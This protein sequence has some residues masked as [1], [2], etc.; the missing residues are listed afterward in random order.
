MPR[1]LPKFL[2]FFFRDSLRDICL[3]RLDS[4]LF[5]FNGCSDAQKH[6]MEKEFS[7]PSSSTWQP[8]SEATGTQETELCVGSFVLRV[9]IIPE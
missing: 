3:T 2:L 7:P 9:R 1:T 4:F 6:C 8:G 5:F